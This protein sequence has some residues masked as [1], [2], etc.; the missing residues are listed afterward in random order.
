MPTTAIPRA[1]AIA[2]VLS[3]GHQRSNLIAL[4]HEGAN[5][6]YQF[7]GCTFNRILTRSVHFN[8]GRTFPLLAGR[9]PA[10]PIC[11]ITVLPRR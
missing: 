7:S 2:E 9:L 3:H 5:S 8:F 10:A 6:R 4:P 11:C 1:I